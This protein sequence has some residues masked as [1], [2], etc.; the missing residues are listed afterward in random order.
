M[1]KLFDSEDDFNIFY[2]LFTEAIKE[3]YITLI[4]ITVTSIFLGVIQTNGINKSVADIIEA[5]KSGKSNSIWK[6]FYMLSVLYI[7]YQTLYYI[8]DEFHG[9]IYHTI[10]PW[11][12]H[13]LLD[14][15]MKTNSE[16]YSG[17][18]FTALVG[19]INR[20]TDKFSW[21]FNDVTGYLLPNI[22]FSVIISIYFA[23]LDVIL[24]SLFCIGMIVIIMYYCLSFKT[25]Y[26]KN[27]DY[28]N[29][30]TTTERNMVDILNNMDKVVYRAEA[31]NESGDF[32]TIS[33]INTEKGKNFQH[34]NNVTNR[35]MHIILMVVYL[36]SIGYLTKLKIMN[37]ISHISFVTS[38]TILMI[39]REKLVFVFEQL[40]TM[41][42]YFSQIEYALKNFKSVNGEFDSYLK[43]KK[44]KS[45]KINCNHFKFENIGFKYGNKSSEQLPVFE[46]KS[47][48][49]YPKSN[50]IVGITG[51]SGCGKSTI[52]KLL[53]KMFPLDNGNIYIDGVNV[54]NIDPFY[55]RKEITYV[56]QN[57]KLFDKRVI[58]NMMYGCMDMDKCTVYLNKIMSYPKISELYKNM[59]II[60]KESGQFG[61]NL[62]GGQR[63]VVNM[64]SGFI[65]PS[66]ILILDEPTNALDPELKR[67]V[68]GLI[69]DFKKYKKTIFIITHD[70]DVFE[71]FDEEIKL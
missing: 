22:V 42:S 25:L 7:I 32:K 43:G 38:L 9:Q 19:P 55:L 30:V 41:I 27:S 2:H 49:I 52:M 28:E 16:S 56:N 54:K 60:T 21:I 11:S 51:P 24:T 31:K 14:L 65:N 17:S 6:I 18:N 53:I 37:K 5:T 58:E 67:E 15:I 62:S 36:V 13:K 29:V 4:I 40:P 20:I 66:K 57:S 35:N 64:I 10:K 44:Y 39:L 68:I 45:Q 8:F 63:Q 46:N 34:M 59:D 23:Q 69:Q 26:K 50:T 33:N 47:I 3:N 70:K 12:R 61:E 48:E 71:I 1:S